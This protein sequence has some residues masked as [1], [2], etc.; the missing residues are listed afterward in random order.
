M[1]KRV[2]VTSDIVNILFSILV[3]DFCSDNGP[4]QIKQ[5]SDKAPG[6]MSEEPGFN[7]H[8]VQTALVPT[9]PP[10]QMATGAFRPCRTGTETDRFSVQFLG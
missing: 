10:I 7:L 3:N 1:L 9:H 8:G 4:G 6:P 5:Y 2:T